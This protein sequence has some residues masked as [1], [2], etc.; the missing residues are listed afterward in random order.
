VPLITGW[1]SAHIN[2]AAALRGDLVVAAL[3][4]GLVIV[5]RVCLHQPKPSVQEVPS[6]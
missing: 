5:A 1:L 6:W 4:L 2:L 3:G